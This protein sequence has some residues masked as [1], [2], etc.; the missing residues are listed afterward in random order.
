MSSVAPIV[1][2]VA[3][4]KAARGE[5]LSRSERTAIWA[6]AID[7]EL[8]PLL[9]DG[10]V[11]S[12]ITLVMLQ[13]AANGIAQREL[14]DRLEDGIAKLEGNLAGIWGRIANLETDIGKFSDRIAELEAAAAR[15]KNANSR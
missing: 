8:K 5:R 14:L 12:A 2:E 10:K 4:V 13:L 7:A 11:G 6:D 3:R 1:A 15:S 9:R